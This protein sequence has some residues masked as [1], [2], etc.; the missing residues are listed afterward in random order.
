MTLK[1]KGEWN[2]KLAEIL[3]SREFLD[4]PQFQ[5][6]HSQ[7]QREHLCS[8]IINRLYYGVYLIG[9]SKLLEKDNTI[10]EKDFLGHGTEKNIAEAKDDNDRAKK[11]KF[12]WV[13]LF[14]YYSQASDDIF[15]ICL[16]AT[17]LH[18]IRNRHDYC[19]S[20]QNTALRDLRT[21]QEQ[22]DFIVKALKELHCNME[23]C[24]KKTEQH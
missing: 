19:A 12:L 8:V 24:H 16:E 17:K 22:A 18:R 5:K 1:E 23:N 21:A 11:S 9:K 10:Q 14:G 7:I 4:L 13:R 20:Q 15:G 3:D 6:E 2:L